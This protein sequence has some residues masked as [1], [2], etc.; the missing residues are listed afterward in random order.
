MGF[1]DITA[2]GQSFSEDTMGESFTYA[3]R[4]GTQTTG[5]VGVFNQQEVDFRME[6]GSIR[7]V[8]QLV[9][10]ASKS[11]FGATVPENRGTVVYGG[12]TYTIE[13]VNGAQS[14]GEPAFELTCKRLT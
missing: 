7:A 5:L 2:A 10:I 12:V 8:T 4:S 9:C 11:Q 6:D 1:N 14:S 13:G 3:T